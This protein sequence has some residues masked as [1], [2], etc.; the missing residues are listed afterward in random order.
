MRHIPQLAGHISTSPPPFRQPCF[1]LPNAL[2]PLGKDGFH[3]VPGQ[4]LLT[5][6]ERQQVGHGEARPYRRRRH[7]FKTLHERGRPDRHSG[8]TCHAGTR[9]VTER[10]TSPR[11]GRARLR[12]KTEMTGTND[13]TGTVRPGRKR[14]GQLLEKGKL[15]DG[16]LFPLLT[17]HASK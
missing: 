8:R 17:P 6:L 2:R 1:P 14:S 15:A 9:W 13:T 4:S 10:I 3:A 11:A 12:I 5:T 16:E 7:P